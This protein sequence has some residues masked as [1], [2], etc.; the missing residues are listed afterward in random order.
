[1]RNTDEAVIV[2]DYQNDFANPETGSL[3][4]N[5]WEKIATSINE[6]VSETKSKGWI[7]IS[8]RELHPAGHISF[9]SNY[10]NKESIIEAFKRGESPS[11]KNFIT[12][13]EVES[14][15]KQNNGIA[16]SADFSIEELKA[17]LSVQ[18]NQMDAVWPNHCIDNT[19]WSEFYKDFD[20]SQVDIEIKKGFEAN[21]HPYSAFGG[22]TLDEKK[23]T[24]D[25]I[26]E[27]GVKIVKVV[28]LATDYCDIATAMDAKKYGFN[29]EFI[30]RATAWVDPAATIDALEKMRENGIK[31]ID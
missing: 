25:I 29:V 14:W 31:I 16:D 11:E 27:Y 10:K 6:V 20:S 24:L 4:V 8:S 13:K 1:M 23:S 12:L 28:G 9:A 26:K 2:V 17:Y 15:T 5:S 3:Y 7:V 18:E 30:K 19:F 22:R 21:T